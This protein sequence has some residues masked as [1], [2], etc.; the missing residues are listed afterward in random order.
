[1]NQVCQPGFSSKCS[2][3]G[4]NTTLFISTPRLKFHPYFFLTFYSETFV[5]GRAVGKH[6]MRDLIY[7]PLSFP[8]GSHLKE[9]ECN[10]TA[11]KGY[12]TIY[13][14]YTIHLFVCLFY[15]THICTCVHWCDHHNE[16]TEQLVCGIPCTTCSEPEP[17]PHPPNPNKHCLVSISIVLL[18]EGY[19][20]RI[21]ECVIF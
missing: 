14:S 5:D 21:I 7:L 9:H 6:N 18:Q 16:G 20:N 10:I 8:Q 12:R 3:M 17:S 1:M 2:Q 4:Q 11:R 13:H 15:S 19:K